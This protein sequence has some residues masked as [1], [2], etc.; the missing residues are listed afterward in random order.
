M[1]TTLDQVKAELRQKYNVAVEDLEH[2]RFII[3]R[4]DE[5]RGRIET[6]TER[7]FAPVVETRTFDAARMSNGGPVD[8]SDLW[9]DQ[10]LLALDSITISDVAL[11]ASAYAAIV[12]PVMRLRLLSNCSWLTT[13]DEWQDAIAVTGTW[14][15]RQTV[16]N[17]WRDTLDTVQVDIDESTTSITVSDS[18][19]ED[20]GLDLRFSPGQLLRIDDEFVYLK[21]IDLD[22]ETH[23]LRC[24]RGVNGTAAITHAATTAIYSWQPEP[25]IRRAATRWVA[26]MYRRQGEFARTEVEGMNAIS[27]PKDMPED[28]M[29]VLEKYRR[30]RGVRAV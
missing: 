19:G 15:Y 7:Y 13:S 2:E 9:L 30:V 3:E 4:I 18:A 11:E 24:I 1:L 16:N 8:G 27:W 10:H 26:L 6:H 22:G 20:A 14:G 28:V 5:V 25:G 21:R 12:P 29:P 23:T 17:A